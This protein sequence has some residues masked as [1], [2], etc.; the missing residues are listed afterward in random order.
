MIKAYE[1]HT[2]DEKQR[3]C[4]VTDLVGLQCVFKLAKEAVA[5]VDNET[6]NGGE[7][8]LHFTRQTPWSANKY[9]IKRT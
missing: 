8:V 6:Q 9:S 3:W 7:C 1:V 2:A 5:R 4:M